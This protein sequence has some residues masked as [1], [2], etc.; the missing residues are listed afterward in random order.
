[1]SR[2]R[3]RASAIVAA[4]AKSARAALLFKGEDFKDPTA[5]PPPDEGLSF[6][7]VTPAD[8]HRLI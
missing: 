6:G 3:Y 8:R 2:D 7:S 1:V 4:Q 5:N